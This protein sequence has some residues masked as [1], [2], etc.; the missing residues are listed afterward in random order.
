MQ[1]VNNKIVWDLEDDPHYI[2]IDFHGLKQF[3]TVYSKQYDENVRWIVGTVFKDGQE[4]IIPEGYVA[5]F[6]CTK[7]DG[8]GIDNACQIIDNKIVYKITLQTTIVAGNFDA[9]FRLAKSATETKAISS[10]K[11][12]MQIDKSALLDETIMSTDEV[13]ILTSLIASA[14]D[15]IADANDATNSAN[16]AANNANTATT[17]S[18]NAEALRVTAENT[19]NTQENTRKTNETGRV[20]AETARVTAENTRNTNENTRNTNETNRGTAETN[21]ITAEQARATNEGTRNTQENTRTSQ[22][23]TRQNYYNAYKVMEAY[24]NTKAYVAGN[25]VS[26]L[27]STYQCAVNSTGNLPTNSSFWALIALKGSDGAG[28]DMFKNVYD[29]QNKAQDVFAYADAISNRIDVEN[30]SIPT[31][32]QGSVISLPNTANEGNMEVLLKGRTDNNLV[33]NGNFANGT[34][35]WDGV[36]AIVNGIA[37]K[38]S[39]VQYGTIGKNI[40]NYSNYK[41]H[42]L[43][44]CGL[45]KADSPYVA[46]YLNDGINQTVAPHSGSS[47]FE[48][49]SAI[50]TIDVNATNLLIKVQDNRSSAWTKFY[51]DYV[52]VID[53]TA[54]YG[55]GKEPTLEQCDKI[56]ENWFDGTKS[57]GATTVKSIGKN[58]FDR[59]TAKLGYYVSSIGEELVSTDNSFDVSQFIE[60]KPNTNYYKNN[61]HYV[62]FYDKNKNCISV[63]TNGV[64]QLNTP[65]NC[66]YIRLNVHKTIGATLATTQFELGTVATVYEPYTETVATT[67]PIGNSLPNGIKDTFDNSSGI[68]TQNIKEY[69]L[70]ASEIV[71]LNSALANFDYVTINKF[72]DASPWGYTTLGTLYIPKFPSQSGDTG[73][74]SSRI[75]TWSTSSSVLYLIFAKGTYA[76]LAAAQTALTGTKIWYQLAN[77]IITQHNGYNLVS[78][79][80]G[81]IIVESTDLTPVTNISYPQNL[82]AVVNGNT[83]AINVL[84]DEVNRLNEFTTDNLVEIGASIGSLTLLPTTN[85]TDL[86]SALTETFQYASNGKTNVANAITAKGVTA[87]S[88][89]TFATLATKI[90]E[91]PIT[92]KMSASGTTTS[93]G[94]TYLSVADSTDLYEVGILTVTGLSFTPS[95][96]HVYVA[97]GTDYNFCV[98]DTY[99]TYVSFAF[100]DNT[101]VNRPIKI[102]YN[103]NQGIIGMFN[104]SFIIPVNTD[105]I[106]YTWT[107]FE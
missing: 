62:C 68:K 76:T 83:K 7:P 27:G 75:G 82:R 39:T 79:P 35:G 32:Y 80:N 10:P 17:A 104:N 99:S 13:N 63:S 22:E 85:K 40:P 31:D 51:L 11:F 52:S 95:A 18:N 87:S 24:N 56:Y 2:D 54:T 16:I 45:L 90:G 61:Y 49:L 48:R 33:T 65:N 86:V 6:A 19:R 98:A 1:I 5:T 71:S 66:K 36:N 69:A 25:K 91:I 26:Y 92:G 84:D 34:T 12:R 103:Q 9:E 70:Q 47:N 23:T 55:A 20:N 67:P 46:I 59:N 30:M 101:G 53:L 38:T 97:G 96:V 94:L 78:E 21:R 29:P 58:L 64:Y 107:A 106:Q 8:R 43:Y 73:D 28:G 60:V 15:A 4:F 72:A 42:K 74:V 105:F 44:F 81:T 41:T 57:V 100:N 89:D 3:S 88:S 77:P 37:E 50:R 102:E 14:G 93:G